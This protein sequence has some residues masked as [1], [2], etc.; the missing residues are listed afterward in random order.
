MSGG[1]FSNRARAAQRQADRCCGQSPRRR[2]TSDTTAPGAK[3]SAT[4]RPLISSLQRR[5]RTAP[6]GSE[7]STTSPNIDANRSV[8]DEPH[9]AGQLAGC[10]VRPDDRFRSIPAVTVSVAR[11]R[12]HNGASR[13][14]RTSTRQTYMV[15]QPGGMLKNASPASRSIQSVFPSATGRAVRK[16]V[17]VISL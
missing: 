14:N 5:R 2:A 11:L 6:C 17:S 16:S 7:A 10:N 8:Q 4:I 13:S 9:V 15:R 3:D 1:S 12:P